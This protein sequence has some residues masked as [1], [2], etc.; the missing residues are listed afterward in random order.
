MNGFPASDGGMDGQAGLR[1]GLRWT[2]VGCWHWVN[3]R[4]MKVEKRRHFKKNV[5]KSG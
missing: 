1:T 5:R 2:V 3:L 4:Y